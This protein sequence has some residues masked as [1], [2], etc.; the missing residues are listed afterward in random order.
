ML[1]NINRTEQDTSLVSRSACARS[2]EISLILLY[3]HLLGKIKINFFYIC[4]RAQPFIRCILMYCTK[5]KVDIKQSQTDNK[6]HLNLLLSLALLK[7]YLNEHHH[8][9]SKTVKMMTKRRRFRIYYLAS[10]LHI[11]CIFWPHDVSN[12]SLGRPKWHYL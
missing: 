3:V 1:G 9:F 12:W 8:G 4:V 11:F 7:G 10:F 6:I 2:M 5:E